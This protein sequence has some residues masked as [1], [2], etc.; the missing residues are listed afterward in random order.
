MKEELEAYLAPTAIIDS[1]H[2]AVRAY[3]GDA[4]RGTEDGSAAKAVRLYYAVRMGSGMTH[5]AVSQT[6]ALPRE[7]R[8]PRRPSLLRRQGHPALRTG[9][10]LRNPIPGRVCR[11][12]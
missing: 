5:T 9:A 11:C 2:P 4:L 12:A 6:G 7:P 10:C 3:A 1:D 8:D